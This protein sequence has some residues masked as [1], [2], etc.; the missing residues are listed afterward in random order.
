[1]SYLVYLASLAQV[2]DLLRA[3]ARRRVSSEAIRGPGASPSRALL[4]G[5]RL[6][7]MVPR[8]TP[9]K[10]EVEVAHPSP[11]RR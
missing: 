9:S 8:Y 7:P 4:G 1:M 5:L 11:E 10:C 3:A 2:D 6:K